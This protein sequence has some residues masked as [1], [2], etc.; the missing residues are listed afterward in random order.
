MNITLYLNSV[1]LWWMQSEVSNYRMPSSQPCFRQRTTEVERLSAEPRTPLS[2]V[3][4]TRWTE[5]VTRT[6]SRQ[7]TLPAS[8]RTK[9]RGTTVWPTVF[10][11]KARPCWSLET[12][13][14]I[15]TYRDRLQRDASG[16]CCRCR[17]LV[18]PR[19]WSARVDWSRR[20]SRVIS[21][22]PIK[23]I[24]RFGRICQSDPCR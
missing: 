24:D 17:R 14:T 21:R 8:R 16:C 19:D 5:V 4:C 23:R 1:A 3:Q 11:D 15:W 6:P 20:P 2:P 13:P 22:V 7:G 12:F 9:V 18:I 10:Q